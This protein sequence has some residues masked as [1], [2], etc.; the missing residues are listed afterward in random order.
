ME[1]YA[2]ISLICWTVCLWYFFCFFFLLLLFGSSSSSLQVSSCSKSSSEPRDLIGSEFSLLISTVD[3]SSLGRTP[4]LPAA[5]PSSTSSV[6]SIFPALLP[7]PTPSR[8]I[9]A[10][11]NSN[12]SKTH[13]LRTEN[14][15][16]SIFLLHI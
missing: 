3:V 9:P 1:I 10:F 6:V 16:R 11:K 13:V 15:N 7:A 12:Q 8:K 14:W 2:S 5:L 4:L